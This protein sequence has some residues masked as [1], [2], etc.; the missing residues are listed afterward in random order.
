M[1]DTEGT[2]SLPAVQ[3]STL[4]RVSQP[5][6][7]PRREAD[8]KPRWGHQSKWSSSTEVY[9]SN[10]IPSVGFKAQSLW[11]WSLISQQVLNSEEI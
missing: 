11:L 10:K 6:G 5:T 8:E 7:W 9:F 1:G 4:L 2:V 3:T